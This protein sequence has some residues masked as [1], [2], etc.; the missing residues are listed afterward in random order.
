VTG[1]GQRKEVT[2]N[3]KPRATEAACISELLVR[4]GHGDDRPGIAVAV[5]GRVVPRSGWSERR[6]DDGDVIEIVGAVQGG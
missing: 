5:N 3:G 2:V 1:F 6:I 4:L